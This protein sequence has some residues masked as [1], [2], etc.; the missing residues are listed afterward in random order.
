MIYDLRFTIDALKGILGPRALLVR[1]SAATAA[2]SCNGGSDEQGVG[3]D[4]RM[5]FREGQRVQKREERSQGEVQRGAFS[6]ECGRRSAE[7]NG[8]GGRRGALGRRRS[9]PNI[10][11]IIRL[12]E[13]LFR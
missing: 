1:D 8:R 6:S 11:R 13:G 2:A 12:T 4:W 5:V 7:L 9:D 10:G 3:R